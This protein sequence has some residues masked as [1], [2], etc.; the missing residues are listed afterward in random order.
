MTDLAGLAH[1]WQTHTINSHL[2]VPSGWSF[3]SVFFLQH[4]ICS[5]PFATPALPGTAGECNLWSTEDHLGDRVASV[6]WTQTSDAATRANKP[7]A[8]PISAMHGGEKKLPE[9][10]QSS[11][12]KFMW[13]VE[14][15]CN[16]A[17]ALWVSCVFSLKY[18]NFDMFQ[19]WWEWRPFS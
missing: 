17:A 4:C 1:H 10:K 6:V 12:P 13:S 15:V 11:E 16:A 3:C 7:H 8:T 18:Q 19:L 2:L 14:G 5:L 9:K